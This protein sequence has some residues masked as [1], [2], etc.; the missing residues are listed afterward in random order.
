MILPFFHG[1]PTFRSLITW[2]LVILN[3]FFYFS[4]APEQDKFDGN[5]DKLYDDAYFLKAQG[6]LFAQIIDQHP[7]E[8][9]GVLNV[10]AYKASKGHQSSQKTLGELAFR[11]FLFK[12]Y[13]LKSQ[14][15]G[16]QVQYSYWKKKYENMMEYQNQD[17]SYILGLTQSRSQFSS[18]ITYQF[19][20]GS[21]FHLLSNLWFLLIFGSFVE[22]I[23]GSFY[24]LLFYLFSGI[25]AAKSF[26]LLSGVSEAPLIGASGSISGLMGLVLA[27]YWKKGIRCFYW[28]LPKEGYHG[29][30]KFPAWVVLLFWFSSDLSGYFGT[31]EELGGVAHAAHI[32]GFLFGC[33]AGLV[34][35]FIHQ[36]EQSLFA[37]Y[38]R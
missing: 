18:Y 38:F 12:K 34:I 15:K 19:E 14:F 8:S 28:I 20:H 22:K 23:F 29:F 30:A 31:L 10:I 16:D 37:S 33:L 27:L 11:S 1:I 25:V 36:R 7:Q 21:V 9:T 5:I 2:M 26:L 6:Q 17:P 4:F 3:I 32:G 13:S 24:F 35:R